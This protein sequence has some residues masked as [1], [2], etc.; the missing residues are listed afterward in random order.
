MSFKFN[1]NEQDS[2]INNTSLSDSELIVPT[3][4]RKLTFD[5]SKPRRVTRSK[6]KPIEVE[7]IQSK[8]IEYRKSSRETAKIKL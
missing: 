3:P 4:T 7:N 8:P 1:R 2:T 6:G 5:T